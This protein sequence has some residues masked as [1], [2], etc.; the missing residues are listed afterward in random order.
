MVIKEIH[1]QLCVSFNQG[2]V[3]TST[4]P[5]EK[6]ER[7]TQTPLRTSTQWPM[8]TTSIRILLVEKEKKKEKKKKE[9]KNF[10]EAKDRDTA[11]G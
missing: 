4:P 6:K 3:P 9:M 10:S 7:T 1:L 8:A 11:I 5:E 2:P